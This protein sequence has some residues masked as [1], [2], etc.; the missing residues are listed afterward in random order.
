MLS[1][2]EGIKAFEYLEQTRP[3]LAQSVWTPVCFTRCGMKQPK[4]KTWWIFQ[5]KNSQKQK[6][7]ANIQMQLNTSVYVQCDI[8]PLILC[9]SAPESIKVPVR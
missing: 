5:E 8:L 7:K 1:D 3:F 6:C 2:L 4:L 9:A